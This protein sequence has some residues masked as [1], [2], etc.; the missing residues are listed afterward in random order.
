V[1]KTYTAVIPNSKLIGFRTLREARDFRG[2]KI[3]DYHHLNKRIFRCLPLAPVIRIHN[4]TEDYSREGYA[5]FW[6][7]GLW[8]KNAKHKDIYPTPPGTSG[9]KEILVL[10][11]LEL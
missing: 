4:L 10:K 2:P 7:E 5:N 1:G 11:E 6:M 8:K 9:C 3:F